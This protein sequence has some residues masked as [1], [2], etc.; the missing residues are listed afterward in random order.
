MSIAQRNRTLLLATLLTAALFAGTLHADSLKGKVIDPDGKAVPGARVHLFDRKT[1]ETRSTTGSSDGSYSFTGIPAGDYLIEGNGSDGALRGSR[2]VSVSGDQT[3]DLSLTVASTSTQVLVT[4]SAVPLSIEEVAKAISAVDADELVRRNEFSLA[5]A[6][7][8]LPGI[9]VKT[10]EGPG[11]F[12]K[13]QTRGLRAQDT[14][15]LIDGMRFHDAASIQND[16]TSFLGGMVLSDTERIEFLRG[17]GSSLYGS[18]ALG[19]VL[20]ITSRPGGGPLRG[21]F[22]V[23]GGGLGMV[24]SV[25]RASGGL[26]SDRLTFSGAGS[27]LYVTNGVRDGL[28]YRNN[29]GQGT[30]K[31]SITPRMSF[32]VREWYVSDYAVSTESPVRIAA[33]AP[34]VVGGRSQELRAIPLSIAELERYEQKQP[35][36]VGD[37]NY[38]PNTIDPDG[39]K[40]GSSSN[41]ILLFQH[42]LP[43]STAY[44]VGYQSLDT[45]RTYLDGKQG[46]GPFEAFATPRSAFYGDVDTLQARIDQRAGQYNRITF[47]YEYERERY[48]SYD[49]DQAPLE[50]LLKMPTGIGSGLPSNISNA[51]LLKQ[52][53]HAFYAQDQIRLLQGRLHLT[54]GARAQ[55]FDLR[56]PQFQGFTTTA[57]TNALSSIAVPTAYTGDGAVAYFISSSRTKLRSHVGNSFRAP[58]GY[59]RFGGGFGSYY[60][61]PRLAPERSVAVDGGIDQWLFGNKAQISGTWFYTNLQQTIGFVSSFAPGTDPFG[62]TFGGYANGGGGIARGL[63]LSG[64]ISPRTSTKI[65]ASY[66][67]VNSDMRAA[68]SGIDYHRVLDLPPH[69]FTMT[70]TQWLGTRTDITFDLAAH[71]DYVMTLGGSTSTRYKFNGPTK[72]DVVVTHRIPFGDDHKLEIYGKVENMLGQQ[73][74]EGGF[75]GPRAWFISGFRINY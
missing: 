13:I 57:Y 51:I 11:S 21:D 52:R 9:R 68:T 23:E 16:A 73:P 75:I 34:P 32:T 12:T 37:A 50:L 33:A 5:E 3:Q 59:E 71:S 70:A 67:F 60:G 14:A 20:N 47:G 49:G 19:G 65:Q 74:Y 44:R 7:R 39:R 10:L 8:T 69:V 42:E 15:V 17:S 45:R 2:P 36:T 18:N 48:F 26:F 31:F 25:G 64:S 63:E 54:A 53:S 28:P 30:A 4:A 46:V 38:I 72:P 29:S 58:S 61:D 27:H 40:Y 6:I 43:S 22:R 24:R 1:G 35:Y 41:N 56:Q 55:T 66:T 62:R